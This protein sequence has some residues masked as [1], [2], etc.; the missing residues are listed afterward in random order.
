MP[1]LVYFPYTNGAIG[2]MKHDMK[3][4]QAALMGLRNHNIPQLALTYILSEP[5][6]ELSH[7]Q[8]RVLCTLSIQELTFREAMARSFVILRYR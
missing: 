1:S 5:L 6:D 4:R 7:Q 3:V 8:S 2:L